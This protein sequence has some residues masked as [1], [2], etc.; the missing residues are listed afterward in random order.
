[1]CYCEPE[2]TEGLGQYGIA[3]AGMFRSTARD[4]LTDPRFRARRSA[5]P[6]TVPAPTRAPSS[7]SGNGLITDFKRAAERIQKRPPPVEEA[8]PMR[9]QPGGVVVSPTGEVPPAG[10]TR[11][12]T[13]AGPGGGPISFAPGDVSVVVEPGALPTPDAPGR[14]FGMVEA[15]I[16]AGLAA[17]LAST[18]TRRK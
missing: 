1:M 11:Y 13:D 4:I 2:G 5:G 18:W 3:R 6:A 10:G 8:P 14:G 9:D 17:L 15:A 12:V 16:A 7:S